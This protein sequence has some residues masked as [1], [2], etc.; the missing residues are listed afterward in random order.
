MSFGATAD[1]TP[2][3]ENDLGDTMGEESKTTLVLGASRGLGRF[4]PSTGVGGPAVAAYAARAGQSVEEFLQHQ[5]PLVTPEIAGAALVDLLQADAAAVA[6]AYLL[7][8][9]DC[10]TCRDGQAVV[11]TK[12]ENK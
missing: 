4:A 10:R 1:R 5:G 7:T 3:A 9:D 8:A 2:N 6:P 11:T 12:R